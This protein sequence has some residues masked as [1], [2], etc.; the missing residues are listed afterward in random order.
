MATN[1]VDAEIVALL[2]TIPCTKCGAEM[3]KPCVSPKGTPIPPAGWYM[4]HAARRKAA[5]P[6]GTSVS[7]YLTMKDG[8]PGRRSPTGFI[9]SKALKKR[10]R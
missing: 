4:W 9:N 5:I 10:G 1:P 2:K 8:T 6:L 7:D 3:G